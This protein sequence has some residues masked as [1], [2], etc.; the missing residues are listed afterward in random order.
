MK[1]IIDSNVFVSAI[2]S[3][4]GLYNAL[5]SK[6]LVDDRLLLILSPQIEKEIIRSLGYPKII[7]LSQQSAQELR[8]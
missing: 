3:P 4:K 7:K 5:L 6:M 1:V 2:I 8:E